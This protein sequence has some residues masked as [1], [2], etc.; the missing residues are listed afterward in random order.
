MSDRAAARFGGVG[1]SATYAVFDLVAQLRAQ[2]VEI[3]DLGGGEPDFDTPAHV[4]DEAVG[5]LREGFTH[6]TP[7][8]GLPALC[9]AIA[10]KLAKDNGI[11]V[12]ASTDVLVTPSAKHALFAAL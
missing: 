3:L 5:A 8:R 10:E 4:V 11:T 1:E 12:D 6:Y 9:E 2:G 7:R